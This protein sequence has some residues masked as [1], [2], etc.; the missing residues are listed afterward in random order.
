M[1]R[2]TYFY[3]DSS[4]YSR[5]QCQSVKLESHSVCALSLSYPDDVVQIALHHQQ[6]YGWAAEHYQAIGLPVSENIVW[7]NSVP[8]RQVGMEFSRYVCQEKSV[9]WSDEIGPLTN[10]LDEKNV[11]LQEVEKYGV[12]VPKTRNYRNIESAELADFPVVIKLSRMCRGRGV[13]LVR[14]PEDVDLIPENRAVQVQAFYTKEISHHLGIA[15]F[16]TETGVDTLGAT[17]MSFYNKF[18]WASSRSTAPPGMVGCQLQSFLQHLWGK[19]LR[20]NL[21]IDVM[22]LRDSTFVAHDC[23]PR[24]SA[25]TYPWLLSKRLGHK[26]WEYHKVMYDSVGALTSAVRA[27]GYNPDKRFGIIVVNWSYGLSASVD[28][29][30]LGTMAEMTRVKQRVRQSGGRF[31][32]E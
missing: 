8:A 5:E 25:S 32:S 3:H 9:N 28:I 29:L 14:S 15:F 18:S 20:G 19:G 22:V 7:S 16:L 26:I 4:V 13:F 27:L 23:N 31:L 1:T 24:F 2:A 10:S 6:D 12:P 21:T 11:F 17:V 30:F